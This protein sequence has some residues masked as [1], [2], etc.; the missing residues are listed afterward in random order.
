ADRTRR[1]ALGPRL[2]PRFVEAKDVIRAEV[3][4][5]AVARVT[6]TRQLADAPSVDGEGFR[7][8]ALGLVYKVVGG[9]VEDHVRAHLVERGAQRLRSG[10]VGGRRSATAQGNDIAGQTRTHIAAKLSGRSE[11]GVTHEEFSWLGSSL[12]CHERA[13][14]ARSGEHLLLKFFE[15]VAVEGEVEPSVEQGHIRRLTNPCGDR[16]RH[17]GFE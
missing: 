13:K 16:F 3:D 5:Q 7:R 14:P 10:Q 8:L 11:Y 12:S 9:A 6:Q 4:E 17:G 2:T 15:R 1:I